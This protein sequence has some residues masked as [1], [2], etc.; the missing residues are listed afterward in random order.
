MILKTKFLVPL[1]LHRLPLKFENKL[2]NKQGDK[3]GFKG[4]KNKAAIEFNNNI[5]RANVSKGNAWLCCLE[6]VYISELC[7]DVFGRQ[8]SEE[9]SLR[10]RK[11]CQSLHFIPL[12]ELAFSIAQ[13]LLLF[14]LYLLIQNPS[15]LFGLTAT[16]ILLILDP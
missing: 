9:L 3:D 1:P 15:L 12:Q 8:S 13:I 5:K 11:I 10:N 4:W 14:L 7:L 6:A 2:W 16:L